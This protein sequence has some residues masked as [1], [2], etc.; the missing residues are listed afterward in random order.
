MK[1]LAI[2]FI[3]GGKHS[4]I[5]R[6]HRNAVLATNNCKLSCGVFSRNAEKSNATALFYGL[7]PKQAYTDVETMFLEQKIDVAVI[8]TPN[9]THFTYAK[10]ALLAGK[11]VI[12]DKPLTLTVAE[13]E[14]LIE[15]QQLTKKCVAV[16]YTYSGYAMVRKAKELIHN[17]TI[18]S[19]EKVSVQY[20]QGWLSED[21]ADEWRLN[22]AYSGSGGA[23]ADIGT[24]AFQMVENVTGQKIVK[25]F[26]QLSSKY[27][28]RQLDDNAHIIAELENGKPVLIDVSQVA[29]GEDNRFI[30]R[31]YGAKGAITWHQEKGENLQL[32]NVDGSST[33]YTDD[34][35]AASQLNADLPPGHDERFQLGMNAIYA[36]FVSAVI[37]AESGNIHSKPSYP[38]IED[39]LRGMKFIEACVS[40]YKTNSWINIV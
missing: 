32:L 1:E 24:H 18:G 12:C 19:I 28:S 34:R 26:A 36:D 39:G 21:L 38:T 3:G 9:H 10:Q 40:S 11:H 13:A 5:G 25:L 2:A 23:I 27:E 35:T 22:P 4:F 14:E 7:S 30:L 16:T 20:L 15:L 6:V 33:D 31:V 8:A 37:Q 29:T 17:G